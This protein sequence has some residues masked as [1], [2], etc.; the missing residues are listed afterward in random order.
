MLFTDGIDNFVELF[1]PL[2]RLNTSVKLKRNAELPER[3]GIG[4][5][6]NHFTVNGTML[7]HSQNTAS[8]WD[9]STF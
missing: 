7:R 9:M 6:A 8:I 1:T 4:A 5:R 2:K 3:G